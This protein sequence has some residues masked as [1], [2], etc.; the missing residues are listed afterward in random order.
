MVEVRGTD[1]TSRAFELAD[2][3]SS[4]LA[5]QYPPNSSA[6]HSDRYGVWNRYGRLPYPHAVTEVDGVVPL[7]DHGRDR[8][9]AGDV[10]HCCDTT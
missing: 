9:V 6:R 10:V 7:A 3:F 4:A 5:G 1:P 8:Q 2:R